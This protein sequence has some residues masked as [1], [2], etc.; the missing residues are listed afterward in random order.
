M[1]FYLGFPHMKIFEHEFRDHD[2]EYSS[3][4]RDKRLHSYS[5]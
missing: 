3:S 2:E 5:Y 1:S 4:A